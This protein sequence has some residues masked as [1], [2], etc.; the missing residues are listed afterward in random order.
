ML[1]NLEHKKEYLERN[2]SHLIQ[3]IIKCFEQKYGDLMDEVQKDVTDTGK[4]IQ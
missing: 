4:E 3:D 2:L 1:K